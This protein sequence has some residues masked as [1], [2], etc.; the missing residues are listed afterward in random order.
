[1]DGSLVWSNRYHQSGTLMPSGAVHPIFAS[2]A[3]QST[4]TTE[5]WIASSLFSSQL[6]KF[7]NSLIEWAGFW[8]GQSP[9][10]FCRQ[11]PDEADDC[12]SR[13]DIRRV[14]W[15]SDR[16]CRRLHRR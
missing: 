14:R 4:E 13:P 7:T 1:M 3:K 8:S 10:V 11:G 2:E 5:E 16:D 15:R 6:C 9:L 12:C